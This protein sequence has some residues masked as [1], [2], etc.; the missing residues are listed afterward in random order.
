MCVCVEGGGGG[1]GGLA[2]VHNREKVT[3]RAFVLI[4]CGSHWPR[5]NVQLGQ[6]ITHWEMVKSHPSHC[7][8]CVTHVHW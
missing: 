8:L 6:K 7:T 1:G 2:V 4:L 3:P 5:I